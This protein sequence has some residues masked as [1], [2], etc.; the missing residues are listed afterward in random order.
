MRFSFFPHPQEYEKNQ[1][2]RSGALADIF[3]LQSGILVSIEWIY[4]LEKT[5]LERQTVEIP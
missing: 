3:E 2:A 5:G 1:M 4:R